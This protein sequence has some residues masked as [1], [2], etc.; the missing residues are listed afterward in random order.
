MRERVSFWSNETSEELPLAIFLS[1]LC[2]LTYTISMRH[3]TL[4]ES[5]GALDMEKVAY[6]RVWKILIGSYI[7]LVLGTIFEAMAFVFYNDRFHPFGN[8]LKPSKG[9]SEKNRQIE[10]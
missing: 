7:F 8:I 10:R 4:V 3:N 2:I 6:Q 1:P 5:I 9:K